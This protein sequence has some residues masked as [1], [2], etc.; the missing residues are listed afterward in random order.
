MWFG[1]I[2]RTM[3]LLLSIWVLIMT[4]FLQALPTD[5]APL[6]LGLMIVAQILV[7]VG[8]LLIANKLKAYRGQFQKQAA[9]RLKKLKTQRQLLA[10][11]KEE[12]QTMSP[13][14]RQWVGQLEPQRLKKSAL[15]WAI[16]SLN[17]LKRHPVA[18]VFLRTL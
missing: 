2:L 9:V 18:K 15:I 6:L 3:G 16:K 12:A 8:L 4:E 10:L 13:K 17:P 1:G 5:Q 11:A 7:L 14:V